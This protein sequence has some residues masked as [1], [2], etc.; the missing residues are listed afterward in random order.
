MIRLST[1]NFKFKNGRK[2]T[3]RYIPV[4]ITARVNN[5]AYRV[6]LP[7]KYYR[8][9]NMVPVSLL[10]PWTAPHD[11]K[12]TPFPD[13]K[14]NQEVYEPESIEIHMDTAKDRQ[15]FVKWRGWPADYNT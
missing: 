15:Y 4:K 1:K 9:H 2:S 3:P 12:K 14:N 7:E 11:L 8:I 13:L 6:R 10:E 5:Q